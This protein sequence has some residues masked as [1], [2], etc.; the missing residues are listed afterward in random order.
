MLEH[1]SPSLENPTLLQQGLTVCP[2]WVLVLPFILQYG[3]GLQQRGVGFKRRPAEHHGHARLLFGGS[4][5]LL[6][7]LLPGTELYTS[8]CLSGWAAR[9]QRPA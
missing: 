8:W 1:Q 2:L 7:L 9:S 5:E 4:G 6:L 3:P